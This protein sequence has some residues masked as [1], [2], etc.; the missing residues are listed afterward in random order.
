MAGDVRT[1]TTPPD[2]NNTDA[3]VR[4]TAGSATDVNDDR[5]TLSGYVSFKKDATYA[6]VWFEYGYTDTQL[7]GNTAALFVNN[8]MRTFSTPLY[9]LERNESYYWRVVGEDQNGVRNYSA[10]RHFT[11]RKEHYTREPRATTNSAALIGAY[12]ATLSGNINMYDERNGT[13]FFVYGEDRTE[14]GNVS[15]NYHRYASINEHGDQLQKRLVAVDLDTKGTFTL[16]ISNLDQDTTI[17][18]A[19]GVEYRVN[20]SPVILLGSVRSFKTTVGD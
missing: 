10:V 1:F 4:V 11:T 20:N 6:Y 7:D 5:A 8:T 15:K 14:V 18:Y 16:P 12:S 2:P 19:I 13:V 3:V 9:N 17:Y